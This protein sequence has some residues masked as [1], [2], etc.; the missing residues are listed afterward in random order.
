MKYSV[1][2]VYISGKNNVVA[3]ALSR[4]PAQENVE[5]ILELETA[6]FVDQHTQNYD[7]I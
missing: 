1:N 2:I 4:Y 7:D 6:K 3:Y 5:S